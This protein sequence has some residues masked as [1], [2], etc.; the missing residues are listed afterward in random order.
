MKATSNPQS[1]RSANYNA[2][3]YGPTL[4]GKGSPKDTGSG[5]GTGLHDTNCIKTL[6]NNPDE[7][8]P[9]ATSHSRNMGKG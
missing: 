9:S 2:A 3:N 8:S 6:G 5:S 4:G 1:T 7:Y